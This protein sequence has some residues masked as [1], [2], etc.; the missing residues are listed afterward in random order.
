[1]TAVLRFRSATAQYA[2]PAAFAAVR[3][4]TSHTASADISDAEC[5]CTCLHAIDLLRALTGQHI[6]AVC[7]T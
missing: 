6:G 2:K 4:R 3:G 7:I 1:M 5:E